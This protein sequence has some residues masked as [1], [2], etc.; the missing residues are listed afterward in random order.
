MCGRFT[1]RSPA[2]DVAKAFGALFD[3]TSLP[4]NW[5]P[6]YNIAP[7]QPIPVI[8]EVAPQPPDSADSPPAPEPSGR[9]LAF[10]H[11]GLIPAWADD[12][13]IGSR[14]INARA[15]TLATKP[16][17]RTAFRRRRCLIPC[18]GIYEW[19]KQGRRKQPFFITA[20]DGLFALAGL[21]EHWERNG[22]TI[23]SCT[24]ITTE[25]NSLVAELHDRMPVILPPDAYGPWLDPEEQEPAR[26]QAWLRPY[27]AEAMRLQAVSPLVNNP[28]N[29]SP[30]CLEKAGQR[31][32]DW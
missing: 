6:R 20:G 31:T 24:I 9:E 26:L 3:E 22:L 27:P 32:F 1:L 25:A 14:L 29:D 21:W 4:L 28:R 17:F 10:L 5:Q 15:E 11:W 13:S 2:R 16:A 7:T 30:A 23:E 18:D 12:P 8:R 19:Q